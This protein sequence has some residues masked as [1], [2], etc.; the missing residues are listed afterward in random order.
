MSLRDHP[1]TPGGKPGRRHRV[2][3]VLDELEPEDA[4]AL[5]GWIADLRFSPEK[6]ADEIKKEGFTI[7]PNSIAS[8]RYNVLGLG[9]R[10]R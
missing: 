1:P 8:Y 2:L 9:E 6:I 7:T 3:E 10:K 4:E 5:R